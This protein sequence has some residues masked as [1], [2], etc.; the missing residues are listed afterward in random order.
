M[1]NAAVAIDGLK[2]LQV[3]LQFA[4]KIAFDQSFIVSD[5]VDDVI[6]LLRRKVFRAQIWVNPRLLENPFC[7]TRPDSV[8]VREGRFD[9]FVG[10]NFDSK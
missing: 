5:C 3:T 4:A 1:P 9:A 7:G 6:D 8:N 10:G 2:P